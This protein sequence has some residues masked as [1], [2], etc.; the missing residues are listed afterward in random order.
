M[1]YRVLVFREN[2]PIECDTPDEVLKLVAAFTT[3]G[4]MDQM[5]RE[6][7]RSVISESV[8]RLGPQYIAEFEQMN[9]ELSQAATWQEWALEML[10]RYNICEKSALTEEF[11]PDVA[12]E[13]LDTF[14]RDL[15]AAVARNELKGSP[16]PA[17]TTDKE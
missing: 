10:D 16:G 6:V 3:G 4:N 7:R 11:D 13:A 15:V 5:M 2:A 9:Q 14:M 8:Q 12:R 17:F 1:A